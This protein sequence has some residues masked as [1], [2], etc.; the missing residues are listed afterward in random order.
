LEGNSSAQNAF[1]A[2]EISIVIN[3]D[4]SLRRRKYLTNTTKPSQ[5]PDV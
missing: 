2:G 4:D 1:P 5:K 3:D